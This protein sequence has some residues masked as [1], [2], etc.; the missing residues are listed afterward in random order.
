ME[1]QLHKHSSLKTDFQLLPK[2]L[3]TT[4]EVCVQLDEPGQR[5]SG[6]VQIYTFV[7]AVAEQK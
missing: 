1:H 2:Y 5:D 6:L 7:P 3:E 4:S